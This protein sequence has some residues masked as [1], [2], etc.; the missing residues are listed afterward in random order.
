[1][2]GTWN[3][4][5]LDQSQR[6]RVTLWISVADR[7]VN[8]LMEDVFE[9]LKSVLADT[10]SCKPSLPLV[11][12]SAKPNS[13]VVGA[14]L[15]RLLE[16]RSDDETKDFLERGQNAFDRLEQCQKDT[17][18][19][20]QGPCLGGGLEFALACRFRIAMDESKTRL[21]LPESQ[22]GLIP[23]WGGTQRLIER[24]GA[25]HGIRMLMTG[26]SIAPREAL[27]IGLVDSIAVASELEDS[28]TEFVRSVASRSQASRNKR[29]I[30]MATDVS[31]ETARQA[32]LP[33]KPLSACQQA[34]ANAI[35]A[36]ICQSKDSGLRA[37]RE[38]FFPLLFSEAVRAKLLKFVKP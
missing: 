2:G 37:E 23:G 36:G 4:F 34:I 13:F 24:I 32:I 30:A 6:D 35:E 22:L 25:F 15:R 27:E 5:R 16:I 14:D 7:S 20:I 21:G 28:I 10:E 29:G 12:R 11:I 19:V 33:F 17:I 8:V 9:E 3:H 18:A 1:M 26:N 38:Q 31:L